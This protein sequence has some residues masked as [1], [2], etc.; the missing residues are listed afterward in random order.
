MAPYI[1][2]SG[3]LLSRPPLITKALTPFERAFYFYQKRLNERLAMPFTRYFYFK[4]DTPADNDWKRKAKERN[5]SPA[6]ELGGYQPYGELGW[7]DEVLVGDK[8]SEPRAMAETLVK[9]AVMRVEGEEELSPEAVEANVERPM[10]RWTEADKARDTKRLDRKLARTLYLLVKGESGKW[11][12]PSG[13]LVGRENLHQ[14]RIVWRFHNTF[15]M[16]SLLTFKSGCRTHL[17]PICRGKHEHLDCRPRSGRIF[18]SKTASRGRLFTARARREDL[19]HER[20]DH[21]RPS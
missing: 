19:L 11:G 5:G 20:Q 12:L 9:D 6:R 14:V 16:V 13:S 7:N 18:N 17:G 15:Q 1:V 21:G 3:V 4:K 2:K 10:E 8:V